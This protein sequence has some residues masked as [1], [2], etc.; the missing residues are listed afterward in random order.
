[1]QA[2]PQAQVEALAAGRGREAALSASAPTGS[3]VGHR[4]DT[5]GNMHSDWVTVVKNFR[6]PRQLA[7][8][9]QMGLDV[10]DSRLVELLNKH[11]GSIE[12]VIGDLFQ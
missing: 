3:A 6:Y 12:R 9:Q 2:G 5:E 7:D 8:M 11:H 4:A 1:M 10:P